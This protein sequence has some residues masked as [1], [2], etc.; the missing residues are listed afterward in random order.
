ML[1]EVY[2][3]YK[4]CLNGHKNMKLSAAQRNNSWSN[5]FGLANLKR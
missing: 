1:V 4:V 5:N 2:K 3:V